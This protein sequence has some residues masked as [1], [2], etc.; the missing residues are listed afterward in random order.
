LAGLVQNSVH[1]G[2]GNHISRVPSLRL[3]PALLFNSL[4]TNNQVE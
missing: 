3:K 4:N 2:R 1:E